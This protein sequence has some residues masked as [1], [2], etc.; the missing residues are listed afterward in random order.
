M[1]TDPTLDQESES[2]ASGRVANTD[3]TGAGDSDVAVRGAVVQWRAWTPSGTS[4]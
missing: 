3:T 4:R 1:E 2:T